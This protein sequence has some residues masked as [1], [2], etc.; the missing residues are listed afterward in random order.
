MP[1]GD[2]T[3]QTA[4]LSWV[5]QSVRLGGAAFAAQGSCEK[6]AG[7]RLQSLLCC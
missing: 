4:R 7:P 3:Q 1:S 6:L 5:E 2:T